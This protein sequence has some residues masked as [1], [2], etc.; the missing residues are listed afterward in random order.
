MTRRFR[1]PTGP[2]YK[3]LKRDDILVYYVQRFGLWRLEHFGISAE[4]RLIRL[5][6]DEQ[7]TAM[8]DESF[9]RRK[10]NFDWLDRHGLNSRCNAWASHYADQSAEVWTEY[11][12]KSKIDYWN[13]INELVPE[14]KAARSR[15]AHE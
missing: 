14:L 3:W 6:K 7:G 8:S 12:G 13:V 2:Q 9:R 11:N 5:L 10:A 1:A 15:S 4:F